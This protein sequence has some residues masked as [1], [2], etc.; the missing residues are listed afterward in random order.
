LNYE[1]ALERVGGDEDLLRDVAELFVQEC[2]RLLSN[3]EEAI[4]HK[5]AGALERSAHELKGAAANFAAQSVVDTAFQLETMG[6]NGDV[7]AAPKV[8]VEMESKIDRLKQDLAS[9]IHAA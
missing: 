8:F 1:D 5:D 9:F 3:I 7:E 6:R 2:P 4:R